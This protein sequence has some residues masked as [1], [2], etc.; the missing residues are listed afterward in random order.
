MHLKNRPGNPIAFWR[1]E[2]VSDQEASSLAKATLAFHAGV[3][4]D[5]VKLTPAGTYQACALGL[6]DAWQG[7]PL[8]RRS[9]VQRPGSNLAGWRSLRDPGTGHHEAVC[10]AACRQL[11]TRLPGGLPLLATVFGPLTQAV[12]LAGESTLNALALSA[13]EAVREGIALLTRRTVRLVEEYRAAGA[14]GIYYVSQHH[15]AEVVTA[16]GLRAWGDEADRAIWRAARGA[17]P[18]VMHFHGSPLVADLPELPPG[19]LAHRKLEPGGAHSMPGRHFAALP[20]EVL[21]RDCAA[22][23]RAAIADLRTRLTEPGS[24]IGAECVVP[25]AFPLPLLARWVQA[26]HAP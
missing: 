4:G 17:G 26:A 12:Q 11:R 6:V 25:T 1:H 5:L 2:P 20:L 21:Q 22:Q 18:N 13:P 16:G 15:Q 23:H 7:D 10:L 9:I 19:W 24:W 14:D 3:G 8:G